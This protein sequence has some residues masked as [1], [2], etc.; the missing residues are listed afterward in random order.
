M[1]DIDNLL[2]Q[3]RANGI[4]DENVLNVMKQIDRSVFLSPQFRNKSFEDTALPLAYGQT[5]SQ[6]SVVGMMTQLLMP[7]AGHKVLEIG[8]GSGYQTIILSLLSR[9]VYTIER[10]YQLLQDAKEKF[11]LFKRNNITSQWG[12]GHEGWIQQAPFKRMMVTAAASQLVPQLCDQLAE[13]GRL[14]I[15]ISYDSDKDSDAGNG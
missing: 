1:S 7:L 4:N 5:I 14:V 3:M 8:T 13:G 10:I 11:N 9:R 2:T 12:D 15:P 6:P